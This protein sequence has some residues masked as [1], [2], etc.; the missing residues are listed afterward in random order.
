MVTKFIELL[1]RTPAAIEEMRCHSYGVADFRLRLYWDH[2]KMLRVALP[3]LAEQRE[4]VEAAQRE[5]ESIDALIRVIEVQNEKLAEYRSALISAAVTG[6]IDVRN[7]HPQEA[8]VL[9]Q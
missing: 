4:I 9:C 3:P 8:A 7:Y 5:T 6:Q 1:L 2:F